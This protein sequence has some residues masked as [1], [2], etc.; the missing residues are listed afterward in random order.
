MPGHVGP[1]LPKA[2]AIKDATMAYFISQDIYVRV[3]NSFT[4]MDPIIANNVKGIL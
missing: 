3:P 4:T 2:Q 1:N